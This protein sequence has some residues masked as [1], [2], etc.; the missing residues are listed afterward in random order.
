MRSSGGT[1]KKEQKWIVKNG[2]GEIFGPFSTEQV[3]AQIDRGYFVG[4]ELVASYPGGQWVSISKTPEFYDRLLDALQEE[5]KPPPPKPPEPESQGNTT[6][7]TEINRLGSKSD[8]KS[9]PQSLVPPQGTATRQMK[10]ALEAG[11]PPR[12]MP[13]QGLQGPAVELTS[14]NSVEAAER[15]WRSK[16][17]MIFIAAAL[18]L[19]GVALLLPNM[20]GERE[21]DGTRIRLVAPRKGRPEISEEKSKEKFRR[22]LISFHTDTFSGYQRAQSELVELV[23]G[24]PANPDFVTRKAEWLAAL[25]LTYRELWPF[26][27]Q[28]AADM[29]TLS[30]VMQEAKRLDPA[31]QNGATCEIVQLLASGRVRDAQGLT[32]SRLTEQQQAPVFFEIRGDIYAY[33]NDYTNAASYFGQARALWPAWQKTRIQEAKAKAELRQY[34]QA[35]LFYR[36]VIKAV[37]THAVAKVELGLLE[38]LEFNHLD[39]GMSLLQAGLDG[40]EKLAR[41]IESSG[42]YGLAI[43]YSR[44]NQKDKALENARKAYELN[45]ANIAAKALI[46]S[47]AGES[48][49][50]NAR[51]GG[52]EMMYL[53]EQYL[54]QGDYFSAQAEFKAAFETDPKNGVAA[55]KAGQCLWELNQSTEAIDWMKKALLAEPQLTGAYVQLADYYAQRYDFYAATQVLQK[56]QRLQPNSYEVYRGMATVELRRQNYSGAITHATR[57]MKIYETDLDTFLVLS[58]AHLGA[59]EYQE[60]QRFASKASE[61]DYN[62]TEAH[63]L[64]A[65]SE[66][67]LRGIEAGA[68]YL[69]RLL[70]KYV[71]T[72]GQQ[73]PQA[74]IE[75]RNALGEI[76]MKDERFRQAEEV[77]RQALSLDPNSKVV[78]VN[79]GRAL[80]AQNYQ[81]QALE[82]FL[83]AAV[84]DPSDAEPIFQSGELYADVGKLPEAVRQYE[85]VL[86]I[87]PRQPRTQVALGKIYLK[88]GD[89]KKALEAA[90]Q[91][92]VLNPD[93]G[94]SYLL[95]ADAYYALKQYSNCAAEYQLA[96]KRQRTA[97]VLVSMARCYRL[98]GAMESAQSL[99]RQA[100]ALESGNPDIYKEQGAIYHMKGMADEAV[101]AYDSYLKL[102]PNAAD[103]SEIEAN[104]QKVQKGDLTVGP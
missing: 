18:V 43:I 20:K 42:Y 44:K 75:Y 35:I 89:A 60:A 58:K 17:P 10:Q 2:E 64:Y 62:S 85:R 36:E 97:S 57:A 103:R 12:P 25:C 49:L 47:L 56:I 32:E 63:V 6:D 24:A 96:S 67:G 29:R 88:Q 33:A 14:I 34:P 27:Y 28:D 70:N 99:L 81:P 39:D 22:A 79:L 3:L 16:L 26:S 74:A 41:P 86:K 48:E 90:L 45:S 92:R 51:V 50:K 4:G 19:A 52:R 5:L 23:E 73:I 102:S 11:I 83:R 31:G 78:L 66:A 68:A 38:A 59:G 9:N 91:E 72:K 71:I 30:G 87:N 95:A 13:P 53:G 80:K 61:I 101:T 46:V 54:R 82:V 93:L 8:G 94:D 1:K 21:D 104:I 40:K 100:E 76:Y 77:F 55:M 15:D 69:Q 65:K 84:L 98:S 37:P 7:K